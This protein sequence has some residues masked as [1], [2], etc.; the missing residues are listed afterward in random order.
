MPDARKKAEPLDDR[1]MSQ[2]KA[3]AELGC[4]RQGVLALVAKGELESDYV[5]ERVV[6][7]RESVARLKAKRVL[8]AESTATV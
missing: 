1:W 5:A 4:S 3:A 8:E 6:I 7:S 2:P